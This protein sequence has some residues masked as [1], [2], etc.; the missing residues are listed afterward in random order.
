MHCIEGDRVMSI[1]SEL[2][3]NKKTKK[4]QSYI[5]FKGHLYRLGGYNELEDANSAIKEAERHVSTDFLKW[6]IKHLIRRMHNVS[7]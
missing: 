4:W 1:I 5:N 6:Y 3:Y 2:R 7:C